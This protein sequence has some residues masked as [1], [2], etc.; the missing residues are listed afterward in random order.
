[1]PGP[2]LLQNEVGMEKRMGLPVHGRYTKCN[3]EAITA[4]ER[5]IHSITFMVNFDEFFF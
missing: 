1:M 5:L 4:S 2:S 3:A